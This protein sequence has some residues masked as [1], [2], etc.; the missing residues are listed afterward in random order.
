MSVRELELENGDVQYWEDTI[1]TTEFDM[2][3]VM[4]TR[5]AELIGRQWIDL[6]KREGWTPGRVQIG[7]RLRYKRGAR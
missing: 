1:Y 5:L 2:Q 6:A 7:W 4:F 3:D